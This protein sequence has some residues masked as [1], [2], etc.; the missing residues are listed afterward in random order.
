LSDRRIVKAQQLIGAAAA[1]A[2]HTVASAADLWPLIYVLPT[3]AAQASARETL[4]PWL[5]Q[6]IS[7]TLQHAA[8]HA[9]AQPLSR[10]PRLLEE[11][12]SLLHAAP[13]ANVLAL[14]QWLKEVDA[15]FAE[16]TRPTA[17]HD[18][19]E[20]LRQRLHATAELIE[21]VKPIEPVNHAP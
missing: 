19:R 2:G 15:N 12:A 14:Q 6:A 20:Q 7:Q 8:E 11:G 9:A 17:L 13:P 5:A 1:L 3:A 18:L 16:A 10:V 21:P 4:A